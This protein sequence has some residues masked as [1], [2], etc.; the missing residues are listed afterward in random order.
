[1]TEI[2]VN[3]PF[4]PKMRALI[5]FKISELLRVIYRFKELLT[6]ISVSFIK[7]IGTSVLKFIWK[8]KRQ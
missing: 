4:I 2:N 6:K 7:E 8:H 5:L 1:M 3:V